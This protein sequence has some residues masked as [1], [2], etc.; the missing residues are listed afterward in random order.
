MERRL[1]VTFTL[2]IIATLAL[3]ALNWW[4]IKI[5]PISTIILSIV[6]L[7]M[8][9]IIFLGIATI[10]DKEMDKPKKKF[11]LFMIADG[12][13]GIVLINTFMIVMA[14]NHGILKIELHPI[15]PMIAMCSFIGFIII[16]F[17]GIRISKKYN[18]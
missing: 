18:I 13:D 7:M 1:K 3:L 6:G 15:V 17:I 16:T 9:S 4:F 10:R 12:I 2:A 14:K 5:N 11:A 8:F